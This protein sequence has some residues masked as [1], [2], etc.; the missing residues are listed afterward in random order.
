MRV[1]KLIHEL[2]GLPYRQR[3]E[4]LKLRTLKYRRIRDDMI[5]IYKML[6]GKYDGDSCIEF[7]FVTVF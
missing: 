3:L 1:T 7:K 2:K 5:E 4:R 6:T